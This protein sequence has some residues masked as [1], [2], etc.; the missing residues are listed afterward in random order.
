[1]KSN[2]KGM[3]L[4]LTL[5][6]SFVAMMLVGAMLYFLNTGTSVSGI[7]KR[8]ASALDAAKGVADVVINNLFNESATCSG[9][10]NINDD[11]CSKGSSIELGDYSTLG[12]YNLTATLLGKYN[13]GSTYF[14]AVK[15]EATSNTGEKSIV[16]FVYKVE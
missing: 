7:Q 5:V 12:N 14:Y 15:V 1:M 4:I 2:N 13:S 10:I 3:A 8:Y 11:N 9:G 6:L 16:E